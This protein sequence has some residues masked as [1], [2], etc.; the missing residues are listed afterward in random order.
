MT[1]KHM[2]CIYEVEELGLSSYFF[3]VRA[4]HVAV[5][6]HIPEAQR[7]EEF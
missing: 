4:L 3:V 5:L 7:S 6:M 1:T 2:P